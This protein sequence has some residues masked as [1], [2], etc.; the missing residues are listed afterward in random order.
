MRATARKTN[1]VEP[2]GGARG[3]VG[4]AGELERQHHVFLR[5]QRRQKLERLKDESQQPLP[6][7]GTRILV[8]C[9][10]RNTVEPDFAARR[11]VEAREQPEQRRL[12]GS[13]ST[14]D[15]DRRA[16]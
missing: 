11:T 14:D 6:Q 4:G 8:L 2:F 7:R 12:A 15:G 9:R 10:E 16:R 3:R 13:R 1:A 5:R